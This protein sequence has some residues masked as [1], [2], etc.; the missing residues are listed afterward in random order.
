MTDVA[1]DLNAKKKSINS[2]PW[3]GLSQWPRAFL[4][5]ANEISCKLAI[6]AAQSIDW[7]TVGRVLLT[8]TLSP[9]CR[10]HFPAFRVH[11]E[12]AADRVERWYV[13]LANDGNKGEAE[14]GNA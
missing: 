1:F 8:V 4:Y 11:Q 7:G 10:W 6:H 9:T 5:K 12:G 14:C 13:P 2:L 3:V